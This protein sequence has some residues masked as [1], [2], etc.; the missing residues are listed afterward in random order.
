MATKICIR[1][2]SSPSCP[3]W[4]ATQYYPSHPYYGHGWH[5][6]HLIQWSSFVLLGNLSRTDP[7]LPFKPSSSLGFCDT[8]LIWF[9]SYFTNNNKSFSVF[10]QLLPFPPTPKMDWVLSP[11]LTSHHSF[12]LSGLIYYPG[13]FPHIP[14][15]LQLPT[16]QTFTLSS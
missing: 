8:T 1:H 13:F 12:C 10:C 2:M 15:T 9:S 14:E 6:C 11:L 4:P 5:P 16:T 7:S 3:G